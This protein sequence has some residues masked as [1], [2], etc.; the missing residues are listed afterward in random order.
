MN[1]CVNTN[2]WHEHVHLKNISAS[3]L[4]KYHSL[5]QDRLRR[6]KN[7]PLIRV[8]MFQCVHKASITASYSMMAAAWDYFLTETT[9]YINILTKHPLCS[10]VCNKNMLLGFWC[11]SIRVHDPLDSRFLNLLFLHFFLSQ[12]DQASKMWRPQYHLLAIKMVH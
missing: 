10:D 1:S 6:W 4:W 12:L 5:S 9:Y 7:L 8:Q 11:V 2:S 3:D